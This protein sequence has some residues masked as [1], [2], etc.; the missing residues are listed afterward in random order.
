MTDDIFPAVLSVGVETRRSPAYQHDNTSRG[1]ARHAVIQRTLAG[2]GW[3]LEKGRRRDVPVGRAML[4]THDEP[5]A[6]GY[7]ADATADYVLHFLSLDLGALAPLFARLRQDFGSVVCLT[8]DKEA[9]ALFEELSERFLQRSFQD[10]LHAAELIHRMIIAIYREQVQGARTTDPIEFGHHYLRSHFRLPIN[11]K[12]VADK[13]GVTREH[14]IRQFTRRYHESPGAL[15]RHLRLDQARSMLATSPG[16]DV[17]TI[18][19][20]SGY[21]SA[22]TFC[23]AY[24]HKFGRSPRAQR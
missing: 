10:R 7:P 19:L 16:T 17:E 4:F 2:C 6:Y 5:T 23:R 12:A 1:Q 13:C 9:A 8:P 14:F 18:A 11:L 24:R 22:N 15:L 21:A 20:A 3:F